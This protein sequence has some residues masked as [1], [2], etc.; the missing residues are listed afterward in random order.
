MAT[1]YITEFAKSTV[2]DDSKH[3]RRHVE[4]AYEPAVTS[5]KVTFT[6]TAASTS[7]FA[8]TTNFIRII[9]SADA[10]VLFADSPTATS[11]HEFLLS[12]VEYWRGV[13]AGQKMSAVAA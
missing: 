11:S 1:L 10:Y 12:N 7:D 13:G 4:L 5:Q 9:V 6:G 8:A 3:V 2:D